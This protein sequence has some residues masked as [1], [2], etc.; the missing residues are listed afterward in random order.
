MSVKQ[1]I[2]CHCPHFLPLY[3][4]AWLH[5]CLSESFCFI[6]THSSVSMGG[7]FSLMSQELWM[8]FRYPIPPLSK[9]NSPRKWWW[10]L[11]RGYLGHIPAPPHTG[12][13]KSSL[14]RVPSWW[15]HCLG[16]FFTVDSPLFCC[17][18]SMT[19]SPE[20]NFYSHCA[21]PMALPTCSLF[22]REDLKVACSS[23]LSPQSAR[24]RSDSPWQDFHFS[25]SAGWRDEKNLI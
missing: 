8:H 16:L 19:H 22:W 18:L 13:E 2:P 5:F 25:P 11:L 17:S 3:L 10:F 15:H 9:Q 1:N 6:Q 7:L 23:W 24:S 14:Y 4:L 21:Q 20:W 12:Q